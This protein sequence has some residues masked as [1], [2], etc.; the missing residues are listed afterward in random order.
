MLFNSLHFLIFFPVVTALY[1]LLPHRP[2]IFMLLAAS[3]YFYMAFI[4]SYILILFV[5]IGIDYG[6]AIWIEKLR[7]GRAGKGRAKAALTISLIANIGFLGFFKYFDFVNTN[8]AALFASLG[9]PYHIPNISIILP[10]G[11]SFHTFQSM[12]Y[13]IEVYRGHQKAER[14]IWIYALYVLFYPQMVAGPIERPQ[15][16]LHQFYERHDFDA[17]RVADGLK[18]MLWGLFKKVVIADRLALFVNAVFDHPSGYSGVPLIIAVYFFAFQIY[19]DFSGY[20]DIAIGAA[21]VMGFRLMDNFNRPYFSKSI[22]EFWSRWHI[23]LSTWFKD[24][25]YIPLGGNRVARWKW[26]R[27]LFIVFLVSGLWHG[28][29]WTFIIWG[30]L[31]GAYLLLSIAT[32]PVREIVKSRLGIKRL[33]TLDRI[34]RMAVTFHLVCF[35]WIFFRADS[36]HDA[37]EL[38]GNLNLADVPR[39][40]LHMKDTIR[41]FHPV[42]S[43]FSGNFRFE[44]LVSI[45]MILFMELVHLLQRHRRMRHFLSERPVWFRW[46]VYYAIVLAIIFLGK[47]DHKQFIYFQ[48]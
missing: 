11:L 16:L 38:I 36:V 10:I 5:L 20:S 3:C 25:L 37:F 47:F 18:L 14:N 26:Y 45:G 2:R 19:C 24:Y 33:P 44:L 17:R 40:L 7:E 46:A 31:H 21:Q 30:A 15:N 6:A 4:P 8:V 28:A 34:W 43:T 29:N 1:F 42:V 32:R 9:V 12:S 27:N 35:A 22:S 13:T 41:V 39:Q 23:S 48:F